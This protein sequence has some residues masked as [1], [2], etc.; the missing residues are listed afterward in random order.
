MNRVYPHAQ[1]AAESRYKSDQIV[2][3]RKYRLGY[4]NAHLSPHRGID[5]K[6]SRCPSSSRSSAPPFH[7]NNELNGRFRSTDWLQ[8]EIRFLIRGQSH[9]RRLRRRTR[10]R[11]PRLPPRHADNWHALLRHGAHVTHARQAGQSPHHARRHVARARARRAART[12]ARRSARTF[13]TSHHTAAISAAI[14]YADATSIMHAAAAMSFRL[15]IHVGL[16]P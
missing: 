12:T 4:G 15:S 13:L 6:P 7:S 9:Y 5:A 10:T 14:T 16:A 3:T 8:I 11:H 1:L 2:Q